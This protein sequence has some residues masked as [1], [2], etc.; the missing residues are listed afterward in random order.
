[1]AGSEFD[2]DAL[3]AIAQEFV[4][5][6]NSHGIYGVWVSYSDID[7][8]GA[9]LVDNRPPGSHEAH[10][11][12]WASQVTEVRTLARGQRFKAK[13]SINN[14]RSQWISAHSPLLPAGSDTA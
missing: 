9:G 14:P 8:K 5:S 1:P 7:I 2:R 3:R 4:H 6:L 10:I 11:V 13:D 12:V